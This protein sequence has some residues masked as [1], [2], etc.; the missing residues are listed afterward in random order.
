MNVY[1]LYTDEVKIFI[2][3]TIHILFMFLEDFINMSNYLIMLY[4]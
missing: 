4:S 3:I 1:V 2:K